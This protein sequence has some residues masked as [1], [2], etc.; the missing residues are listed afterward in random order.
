MSPEVPANPPAAGGRPLITAAIIIILGF[1]EMF[2]LF[3]GQT[4]G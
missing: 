2:I 4:H 1:V 3:G